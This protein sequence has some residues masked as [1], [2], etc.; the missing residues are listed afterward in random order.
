M[1]RHQAYVLR[2]HATAFSFR[3]FPSISAEEGKEH[4]REQ[5]AFLGQQ[6]PKVGMLFR[7]QGPEGQ[8]YLCSGSTPGVVYVAWLRICSSNQSMNIDY[9][10]L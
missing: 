6:L 5:Q 8:F 3:M 2:V 7:T 10:R 9:L 4:L 1:Q